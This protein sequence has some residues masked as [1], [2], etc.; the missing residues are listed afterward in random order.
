MSTRALGVLEASDE[1]CVIYQAEYGGPHA[2]KIVDFWYSLE[3]F[4]RSIKII[5]GSSN[6]RTAAFEAV[7]HGSSPCPVAK[8]SAVPINHPTAM[9]TETRGALMVHST[10]LAYTLGRRR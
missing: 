6:G 9:L 4:E 8:V 7:N 3:V 2:R 5:T 10:L 1:L